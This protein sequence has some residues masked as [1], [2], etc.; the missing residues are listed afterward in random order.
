MAIAGKANRELS[1]LAH[2]RSK[3]SSSPPAAELLNLR[4]AGALIE[5]SDQTL[6]KHIRQGRLRAYYVGP[7]EQSRDPKR[8]TQA[9]RMI[10]VRPADVLALLEQVGQ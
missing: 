9:R 6:L 10:R 8:L 3:Q 1:A 4:H 2:H 7:P 5:V